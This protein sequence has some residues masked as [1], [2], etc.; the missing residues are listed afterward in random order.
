MRVGMPDMESEVADWEVK[1]TSP[2][3]M[4][5]AQALRVIVALGMR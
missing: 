2:E 1:I 4:P 3:G 5:R